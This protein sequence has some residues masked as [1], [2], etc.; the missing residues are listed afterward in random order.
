VAVIPGLRDVSGEADVVVECVDVL[1]NRGEY[2]CVTEPV[3]VFDID[4]EAV[5]V[6]VRIDVVEGINVIDSQEDNDGVDV[7]VIN[8]VVV[9]VELQH[10]TRV[11]EPEV[12]EDVVGDIDSEEETEPLFDIGVVPECVFELVDVFVTGIL[13]EPVDE[14]VDV[15]ETVTERVAFA[16]PVDVRET[17]LLVVTVLDIISVLE[18]KAERVPVF[19]AP[20]VMLRTDVDVNV[21]DLFDEALKDDEPVDVFVIVIDDVVVRLTICEAVCLIDTETEGDDVD[22]FDGRIL[23]ELVEEPVIVLE[24]R[25]VLDSVGLAL[26]DFDSPADTV[27]VLD[28]L[29][30]R[31]DVLDDVAVVVPLPVI[32]IIALNVLVLEGT[33]ERVAVLVD[34]AVC[35]ERLLTVCL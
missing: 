14:T 29:I 33:V 21:L 16:E 22:V 26:G 15:R 20:C 19:D 23:N 2:D 1:L 30:V 5:I 18:I 4:E 8:G 10:A 9:I 3:D 34:V 13:R 28:A 17:V 27:F 32:E 11:G 31:V 25:G 12:A 24:A 6:F 7:Y 35:V